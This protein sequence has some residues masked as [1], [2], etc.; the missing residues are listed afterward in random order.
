MMGF[1]RAVLLS[2]RRRV[3]VTG[4]VVFAMLAV[5]F[6]EVVVVMPVGDMMMG[7]TPFTLGPFTLG[8]RVR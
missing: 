2:R 3:W 1:M 6:E 7:K 5:A 8:W 4:L